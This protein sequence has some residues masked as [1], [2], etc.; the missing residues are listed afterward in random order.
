MGLRRCQSWQPP[1]MPANHIHWITMP[2]QKEVKLYLSVSP[3]CR[4]WMTSWQ[5]CR[6]WRVW[7]KEC[8]IEEKNWKRDNV[9]QH[10]ISIGSRKKKCLS[11]SFCRG[12]ILSTAQEPSWDV[13][14]ELNTWASLEMSIVISRTAPNMHTL[15][16]RH[17]ANCSVFL[18]FFFCLPNNYVGEPWN[19][20]FCPV[21]HVLVLCSPFAGL[22]CSVVCG[23]VCWLFTYNPVE[24]PTC[25]GAFVR[26]NIY[27][28]CSLSCCSRCVLS[29]R[30]WRSSP[31]WQRY[32]TEKCDF[33][34]KNKTKTTTTR[35]IIR[36]SPF[37]KVHDSMLGEF[38]C[39]MWYLSVLERSHPSMD[40]SNFQCR[41]G[42]T[43]LWHSQPVSLDAV[44]Y[45]D[46]CLILTCPHKSLKKTRL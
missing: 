45:W 8:C 35:N 13:S 21:C 32:A 44:D 25:H 5:L 10:R 7:T 4:H 43:S 15:L 26:I 24:V 17:T 23:V 27:L 28:S 34:W 37:L 12:F 31:R 14:R 42:W 3:K 36:V 9:L 6:L 2:G 29:R 40:G 16:S 39:L 18:L 38:A 46:G 19:I 22:N 20:V 30:F 11:K 41:N 33:L 1:R